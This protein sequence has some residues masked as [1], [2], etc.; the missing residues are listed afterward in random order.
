MQGGNDYDYQMNQQESDKMLTP[1]IQPKLSDVGPS[2]DSI[3]QP[4]KLLVR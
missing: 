2:E 4:K 3:D 1:G